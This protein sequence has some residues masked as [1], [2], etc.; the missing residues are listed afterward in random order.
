MPEQRS[1]I[2]SIEQLAGASAEFPP[3]GFRQ[4]ESKLA[5]FE[6]FVPAKKNE[7]LPEA[8]TSNARNAV[9]QMPSA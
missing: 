9:R 7:N 3:Q 4:V 2:L 8:L 5:G 6:V 1:K